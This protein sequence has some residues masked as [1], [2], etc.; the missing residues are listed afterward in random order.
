MWNKEPKFEQ[1]RYEVQETLKIRKEREEIK[2]IFEV[3]QW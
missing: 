3:Y 1:R 2:L